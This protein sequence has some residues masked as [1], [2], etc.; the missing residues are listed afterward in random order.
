VAVKTQEAGINAGIAAWSSGWDPGKANGSFA[1]TIAPSWILAGIKTAAPDTA[2]KWRVTSVPGIRGNWGGSVIAIPARAKH[3]EAAWEYI[4][5]L[6]STKGQTDHFA[7]TGTLPAAKDSLTSAEV[8]SYTDTFYGD[9]PIGKVMSDSVLQFNS[10]FN[11]PDTSAI[12]AGLLNSLVELQSGNI[13]A[14][15]AWKT[16]VKNVKEALG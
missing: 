3:P 13:S 9:S 15:D 10:F 4:K 6:M 7:K 5:T 16:G 8:L 2:G 1:V 14:N 12:G 11:G